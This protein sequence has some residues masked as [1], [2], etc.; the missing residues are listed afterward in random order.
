MS[1]DSGNTACA[2]TNALGLANGSAMMP[3][4]RA[5]E[6]RTAG[7]PEDP[8]VEALVEV[9]ELL[10][11]LIVGPVHDLGGRLADLVERVQGRLASA[12]ARPRTGPR[13]PRARRGARSRR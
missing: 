7:H 9:D 12:R 3:V 10:E 13:C 8:G 1:R 5:L 11:R 2:I 6:H 4:E